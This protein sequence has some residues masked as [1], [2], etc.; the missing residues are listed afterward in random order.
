MI[1]STRFENLKSNL[2]LVFKALDNS[3]FQSEVIVITQGFRAIDVIDNPN[4]KEIH[5]K[6]KLGSSNARNMGIKSASGDYISFFDD[7]VFPDQLFFLSIF[8]FFKENPFAVACSGIL[9]STPESNGIDVFQKYKK[10]RKKYF[11]VFDIWHYGNGNSFV[12]KREIIGLFDSRLGVGS[13]FGA[14]ED[15]DFILQCHRKGNIQLLPSAI[16]YHPKMPTYLL[17]D[18]HRI[19]SYGR[20]LSACLFKNFSMAGLGFFTLSIGKNLFSVFVVKGK[21]IKSF[22]ARFDNLYLIFIKFWAF[23]EWSTKRKMVR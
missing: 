4:F 11:K 10:C 2:P 3:K 16:I 17:V 8:N 6:S 12:F 14:F 23:Y 19:S 18:F 7:D 9:Q 13:Y 21:Y 15:I 20:G 22:K 5:S 1:I